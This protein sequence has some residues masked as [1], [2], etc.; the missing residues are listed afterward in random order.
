MRRKEPELIVAGRRGRRLTKYRLCNLVSME[1][2]RWVRCIMHV[3]IKLIKTARRLRPLN[4]KFIFFLFAKKGENALF[5]DSAPFML[6]NY[7][8]FIDHLLCWTVELWK[9]PPWWAFWHNVRGVYLIRAFGAYKAVS[10]MIRH[11]LVFP[12]R[13]FLDQEN[14]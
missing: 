7:R 11:V 6:K 10:S 1:S 4:L 9:C 2:T 8:I 3:N 13:A 12:W 5:R 14:V